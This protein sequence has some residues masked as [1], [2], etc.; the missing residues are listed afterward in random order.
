M[1]TIGRVG[2]RS[3]TGLAVERRGTTET[4]RKICA[5]TGVFWVYEVEMKAQ[6]VLER[7]PS[8]TKHAQ[9]DVKDHQSKSSAV[10]VASIQL[11]ARRAVC[12]RRP[13]RWPVFGSDFPKLSAPS[14]SAQHLEA[15]SRPSGSA[16][17]T[18][19]SDIPS[20]PPL[21][22]ATTVHDSPRLR[23]YLFRVGP[24]PSP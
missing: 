10:V 21:T 11:S 20:D 12:P 17:T 8:W 15:A 9:T 2:G 18:H 4:T 23:L 14:N 16:S 5:Y 7:E 19:K 24:Y 3:S 1:C 13:L 22:T 6:V